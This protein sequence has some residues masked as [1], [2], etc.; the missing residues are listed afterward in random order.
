MGK[1][2]GVEQTNTE[3]AKARASD[4]KKKADNLQAK[5]E[6]A[7]K[8]SKEALVSHRKIE[9]DGIVDTASEARQRIDK[10]CE[11]IKKEQKR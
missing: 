10:I 8:A 9:G 4:E 3:L 2:L 6:A 7:A 5:L 11:N 1:G